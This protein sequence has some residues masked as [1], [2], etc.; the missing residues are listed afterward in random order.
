MITDQHDSY[1]SLLCINNYHL[2]LQIENYRT[3]IDN[4]L[5]DLFKFSDILS[6]KKT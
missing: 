5:I 3:V 4:T 6:E 1:L 2:A